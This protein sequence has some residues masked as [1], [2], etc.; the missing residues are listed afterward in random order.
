[1]CDESEIM[2]SSSAFQKVAMFYISLYIFFYYLTHWAGRD[3]KN[4]S[5]LWWDLFVIGCIFSLLT[6]SPG[7]WRT[8][9]TGICC[10]YVILCCTVIVVLVVFVS[11]S[12]LSV[13]W[14]YP[15]PAPELIKRKKRRYITVAGATPVKKSGRQEHAWNIRTN[16][17]ADQE[18]K[19]L[20]ELCRRHPWKPLVHGSTHY[21]VYI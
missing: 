14:H 13:V 5:L 3:K 21:L 7:L 18:L 16:V 4:A 6:W 15:L 9:Y 2:F 1:M 8:K 20:K 17:F 11:T 10:L 19:L 12:T